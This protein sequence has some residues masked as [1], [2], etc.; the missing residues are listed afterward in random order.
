[1]KKLLILSL[2]LVSSAFVVPSVEA[3]TTSVTTLSAGPQ[4][5]I[6]VRRNRRYRQRRVVIRTRITRIGRY[7]YRETIRTTYLPNGRTRTRVIS[8]V[9]LGRWRNY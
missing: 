7:R 6:R 1:M 4:V 5:G 8:R 9:R 3:K 2:I